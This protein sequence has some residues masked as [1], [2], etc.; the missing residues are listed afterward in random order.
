MK[1]D[2]LA[3]LESA[4]QSFIWAAINRVASSDQRH[5]QFRFTAGEMGRQR[6][7]DAFI[8]DVRDFFEQVNASVEFDVQRAA[9]LVSFN[10]DTVLMNPAQAKAFVLACEKYRQDYA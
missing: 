2:D 5:H 9:F 7:H 4:L 8:D 10:L 1:P 3:Y 6:V